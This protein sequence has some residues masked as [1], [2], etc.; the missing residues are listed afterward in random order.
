MPCTKV[1]RATIY[2][3][4]SR[5]VGKVIMSW[6]ARS[7]TSNQT[8]TF[9]LCQGKQTLIRFNSVCYDCRAKY[10]LV[11][12]TFACFEN[13]V[14]R[15]K[16]N[17]SIF[18]LMLIIPNEIKYNLFQ[19]KTIHETAIRCKKGIKRLKWTIKWNFPM[20]CQ[21]LMLNK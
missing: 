9:V 21:Y 16:S 11:L 2:K 7:I 3:Q 4:I 18:L 8:R 20:L 10:C 12:Y 17:A 1:K 5:H 19:L 13:A 14:S 6:A 15:T